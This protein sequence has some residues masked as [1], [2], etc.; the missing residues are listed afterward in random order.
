[1][2]ECVTVE[3]VEDVGDETPRMGRQAAYVIEPA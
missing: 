2:P 1:M 3:S